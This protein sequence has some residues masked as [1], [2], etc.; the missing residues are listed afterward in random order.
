MFEI[1]RPKKDATI[2]GYAERV[3]AGIDEILELNTQSS[4]RGAQDGTFSPSRILMDFPDIG[5]SFETVL[6]DGPN[7]FG[8]FGYKT[9]NRN[10]TANEGQDFEGDTFNLTLEDALETSD[11]GLPNAFAFFGERTAPT[12]EV[13]RPEEPEELESFDASVWIRLWFANGQGLPKKYII[14]AFPIKSEWKEGRGRLEN[15]PANIE[16]SSWVKRT[17]I[18]DWD[19]PGG[20]Y[21]KVPRSS[22]T[23]NGDDPDVYMDANEVFSDGVENGI[24]IKRKDEDFGRF[25]QLKFFSSETRTIY[26]P[27]LLLGKD[28]Y[29]FKKR[30]AQPLTRDNFTVYVNNLKEKYIPS[31]KRFKVS[32]EEKYKQR[33]FLGIRPTERNYGIENNKYLPERS[34]MWQI[35]DVNSGVVFFPFDERYSAVSFNG[36]EHY[37]DADLSNLFPKRDYKIVFK[38]EDP[39][40]GTETFF[41][42]NQTFQ[43]K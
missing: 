36:R 17:E 32:V 3:N 39:E 29:E 12:R 43:V 35:E 40:T 23:F 30:D 24:L 2:Y 37:F 38:Y 18:R 8:S 10:L 7:V 34:L 5:E 26:V 19:N 14:E 20:D 11:S 33:D 25:T 31:K 22:Q 13:K 27:H 21:K 41:D 42:N 9:V 16:P 28:T 6:Q 1:Y 4:I 15:Q